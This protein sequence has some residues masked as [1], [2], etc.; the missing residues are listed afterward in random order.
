MMRNSLLLV[1]LSVLLC[2]SCSTDQSLFTLLEEQQTGISFNNIIIHNDSLNILEY[3]YIYNG[4]GVGVAD[5]NND[6]LQDLLFTGNVVDNQLYINQGD[7]KFKDVTQQA[8]LLENQRWSTGITIVDINLD[9]LLDLYITSSGPEFIT[10]RSN[11]LWICQEITSEGIPIYKELSSAYGLSDSSYSTHAGFFDYDNDED[12]DLIVINNDMVKDRQPSKYRKREDKVRTTRTDLLFRNDWDD[13]LGH[14]VFTDVSDEAGIVKEGFSLGL[15]IHDFNHDGWKDIFITNDYLSTDLLYINQKDGTF[16]D[17]ADV[18]FKHTSFSAMGNDVVDLDNDGLSEVVALDMLPHDNYRK[19]TMLPPN[20]YT[21]YINNERYDYQYQHVRNTLQKNNF[22]P[23][24]VG[25]GAVFS[26]RALISGIAATDW[27]WAPLVADFD[28]DGDR[29]MVVTNGFPQD[30]TDRD[31]IDYNMDVGAFASDELL[32]AKVPSVKIPN[33]AFENVGELSF[34]RVNQEWGITMPSFSNGAIY[35]DLDNDG[36]LDIVINNIN[37]VASIYK[38][39]GVDENNW[40]RLKI[41]GSE[42][43]PLGYGA[44]VTVITDSVEQVMEVTPGHGY[45]SSVETT[46]H[47]GLGAKADVRSIKVDWPD[48]TTSVLSNINVNKET[49]IDYADVER[50]KK[51]KVDSQIEKL[52]VDITKERAVD[53]RHID[54]DYTDYNVQPMLLHKLSQ[55]GPGI[56]VGDVDADGREDFYISG[57]H[58]QNGQLYI[59]TPDG[60]YKVSDNIEKKEGAP[61]EEL[62]VL[63]FDAD[64]DGDQDLYTALGGYE[65]DLI[66]SVYQ[67]RLYVN[68]DGRL[69]LSNSALPDMLTSSS[70]VTAGDMDNDGDLDLFV[71]GRVSPG[72]YPTPVNSYI[73]RNDSDGGVTTFTDVS[74][75]MGVDI[76]HM[77]MVTDALW[78]D[79]NNDDQ[80]D[81]I[82]VGEFMSITLLENDGSSFINKTGESGLDQYVGWWNSISAGDFD[83]DGDMDYIVGNY[84]IHSLTE[85]NNEHPI[86][87]Y[88]KDFDNNGT[89]DLI[90]T[91]WFEDVNGVKNEYPYFGRLEHEKQVVK[92]KGQ[93]QKHGDYASATI[94]DILSPTDLEDCL[95][96]RANYMKSAY[97]E[98]SGDGSFSLTALPKEAQVA[99]L[100]GSYPQDVNRDGHLDIIMI[101]NDHGMEVSLGRMDALDGLILLGDGTGSFTSLP[102]RTSGFY[103]QGDGKSL[104]TIYN[105]A[106]ENLDIIAGQNKGK[107]ELHQRTQPSAYFKFEKGDRYAVMHLEDGRTQK[108]ER[109]YGSSF[110]SQS[111]SYVEVPVGARRIEMFNGSGA[112][113]LDLF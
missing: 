74:S 31:F 43:N 33:V 112:R 30:V 62:G 58:F 1:V 18:Y 49:T 19:K 45:I 102:G 97:L 110:L 37:E 67:D 12:L 68:Q 56:A 77:G 73:L 95:V 103:V 2:Y 3:E 69:E 50:V 10:N 13:A 38:N 90:P 36:D 84:G 46:L 94:N 66:D 106:Q 51:N 72:D 47:F 32:L 21:S 88:Y 91:C 111:S 20:N 92:I 93:F 80:L 99:P 98:N 79:Y 5:L 65:F 8:G 44:I 100:Y 59:Q 39:N 41:K 113:D 109:Y 17:Q 89:K 26:E 35:A 27:S 76:A 53:Y 78:T 64:N 24:R 16:I 60:Q 9:G 75:D 52:F 70:V 48:Q 108:I 96:L 55:Y 83:K 107:L 57:S 4:G 42:N 23:N 6:G 82:I 40:I 63:F 25:K 15:N 71:G 101:G 81:L 14:P 22:D 105:S 11:L 28:N 85:I 54:E 104:S 7:L 29:D 87:V 86:K 34:K 61:G